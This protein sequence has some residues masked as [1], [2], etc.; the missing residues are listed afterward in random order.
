M[1]APVLVLNANYEPIHVCDLRRALG[2]LMTEK[3]TLVVNG[4]GYIQSV[5]LSLP[6]PSVIRLQK[7][8]HRPRPRLKLTRRE[9]FRRD[10]FTC[11]YCGK[12]TP[13][14]TIDH[15]IPR[16][17]GG[18]HNW[19]NVVTAC[20]ACNHRKGGRTPEEAGMKLL[21][22]PTEPPASAQY[23]FGRHLD[24]CR[25]WAEFLTGW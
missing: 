5:H 12:R 6:I 20:P 13:E 7:M 17:L 23:I 24:E 8:I 4:R 10:N 19:M 9:V 11:Q 2:L 3:A 1:Q 22:P 15:V 16:H 21:H 25:E 14:L 18:Q